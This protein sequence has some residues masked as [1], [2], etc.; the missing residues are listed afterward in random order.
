MESKKR[1]TDPFYYP[2]NSVGC[3]L[4]HGFTGAPSEVVFLGERLA[5]SRYTVLGIRLSGHGSTPEEMAKTRWADWIEDVRKGIAQLRSVCQ[6]VVAVGFSMG[7]LLAL[8]VAAEGLVDGVAA[9]NAPMQLADSR[10]RYAWLYKRFLPY[11]EKPSVKQDPEL[12]AVP[13]TDRFVYTTVPSAC[14]DSLNQ[15]MKTVR[16]DLH[17]IHCPVLLMQSRR[18]ETIK[19]ESVEIIRN[20]ITAVKPELIYWPKSGHMLTMGVEREQVALKVD[21]FISSISGK[22]RERMG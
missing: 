22:T 19:S 3:L 4:I 21:A 6:F 8:A 5:G 18:D 13:G 11:V 2:G 17:K 16:R 20:E 9:L 1:L 15:A 7:G 14:L 12:E 10:T